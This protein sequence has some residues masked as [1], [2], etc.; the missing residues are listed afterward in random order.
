[1]I[2]L[3]IYWYYQKNSKKNSIDRKYSKWKIFY[4]PNYELYG[5]KS[6]NEGKE[7]YIYKVK[8]YFL[9]WYKYFK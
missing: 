9:I 7:S 1:M 5:K 3:Y 4:P 6:T 8:V 2:K